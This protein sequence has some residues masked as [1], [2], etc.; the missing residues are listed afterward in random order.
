MKAYGGVDVRPGSF[1]PW[2]AS[3]GTH[4]II[5]R[6][7]HRA[8]LDDVEKRKFLNIPGLNSEPLVVQSI[9]SRYIDY[10][11]PTSKVWEV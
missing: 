2:E 3:L 11:I 5:G 7:D 8:S 10:A 9:T 1:A 6:V 4:W